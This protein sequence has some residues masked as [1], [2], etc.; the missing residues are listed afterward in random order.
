[1]RTPHRLGT[2]RS[3]HRALLVLGCAAGL[4]PAAAVDITRFDPASGVLS[5]P[6]VSVGTAT[7]LNLSFS[8]LGNFRFALQGA[9][10]QVPA[11]PAVARFDAATGLLT[12]PSVRVGGDTYIDVT[13]LHQGDFVF[14]LQ[15]GT[16][17]PAA[18]LQAATALLQ[19]NDALWA[20]AVPATGAQRLSLTDGC[21]RHDGRTRAYDLAD[22][23]AHAA[24]FQAQDAYRIGQV[25]S[26][27][28]VLALRERSNPDGST[29]TEADLLYDVRYTDGSVN[30]DI[31]STMISGSSAGTPGCSTP[32]ASSSWRFLGNQQLVQAL[33]RARN[34]RDARYL[35]ASGAAAT[36]AVNYR[37]DVQFQILDPMANATYVVISGPGPSATVDGASVPFSLKMISPFVLRSAPELAGKTGNFLNWQD[38][39][40]FRYCRSGTSSVPVAA[41]ADCAGQGATD[42]HWGITTSTPGATADANFE[43]QGWVAGGSYVIAVYNDDGWKTVNGHAGRTPI[44][45]YGATLNRLPASFVEMAG[46][47]PSADKFPRWSFGG[48]TVLQVRNNLMSATPAPMNVSWTSLGSLL[49]N[50][51]FRLYEA[52][53]FFQGP[54][55]GNTGGAFYPAYRYAQFS[56][57]GSTASSAKNLPVTA[58]PPEISGKSYAE[59][60]LLFMDRNDSQIL[61]RISFN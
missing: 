19:A 9:T 40:G 51:A 23:D 30:N 44:A 25:S 36:P 53:E 47:G 18:T 6:S 16:L 17:L 60:M 37:R 41:V 46:S 24:E 35:I 29:R 54:K 57:P 55:A 45:T 4:A 42:H 1:M 13:L 22:I 58:R 8:H 33:V 7:Y 56:F 14:A 20:T 21:Y 49:D 27:L 50:R 28:R 32:Q 2:P 26:N 61:S 15:G 10:P 3:I 31:A 5:T 38:D 43:A 52:W 59:F 34:M 11:G 12:L 39:D 48:S